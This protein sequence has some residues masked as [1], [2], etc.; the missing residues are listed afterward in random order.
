VA[1][2][3][4]IITGESSRDRANMAR[5]AGLGKLSLPSVLAGLVTAFGSFGIL[6]GSSRRSLDWSARTPIS[7]ALTGGRS[8]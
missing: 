8:G 5:E 1:S 3:R 7:A 6:L 2:K 4:D